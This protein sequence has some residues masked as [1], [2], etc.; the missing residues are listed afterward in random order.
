MFVSL[1]KK[2]YIII[3]IIVIIIVVV[4]VIIIIIAANIT[5]K[6]VNGLYAF[7]SCG[8]RMSDNEQ[9]QQREG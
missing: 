1:F 9:N 3:I 5:Q 2:S 4:V 7:E 6:I 8:A